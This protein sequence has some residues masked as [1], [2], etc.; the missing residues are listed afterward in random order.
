MKLVWCPETAAKAYIDTVELCGVCNDSGI[1]ELVSSM[2]AGWNASFIVEAWSYGGGTATSIGLTVA[3]RHTNGRHVCIVPD[4]RSRLEY[5]KA[6]EVAGMSPEVIVGEPEK[7]MSGLNG[8][9]FLV[10]D[11]Q[12]NRFSRVLKL[13]K[14][15]NKG[16]VMVCKNTNSRSASSFSWRNVVYDGSHWLI[17]SIFLPVGEG[18][19]IAHVGSCAGNSSSREGKRRWIKHVNRRTGEEFAIRK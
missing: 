12:Q 18:L 4:E 5:V 6:L 14:L 16:A 9:D 13:A 3:C 17:R 15:S 19:D 2:A 11:S 10:V 7:L 8:I 1:A